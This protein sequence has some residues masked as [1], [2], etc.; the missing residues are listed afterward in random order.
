MKQL[1]IARLFLVLGAGA[2]LADVA[3][4]RCGR[5]TVP[6]A[7]IQSAGTPGDLT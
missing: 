6:T 1:T 2:L 5:G 3:P 7:E 4:T